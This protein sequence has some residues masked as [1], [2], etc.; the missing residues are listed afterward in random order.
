MTGQP[1]P[2]F[3][4]TELTALRELIQSAAGLI[5]DESRTDVLVAALARRMRTSGDATAG[6]YRKRLALDPDELHELLELVVVRE[7]HFARIPPQIDALRRVILPDLI[8]RR[9][10]ERRLRIWSAGCSTG[11]E[12]WTLAM[13]LAQLLPAGWDAQ[14][15]GTDLS[16]QALQVAEG[17][18]YGPRAVAQ[19]APEELQRWFSCDGDTYEIRAE[20]RPLVRFAAHNLVTDT[21]PLP[22][23]EHADLILCR[24]VT[25]YFDRPTTRR[26]VDGFRT[27]LAADGWLMMG[28]SETLWRLHDGFEV[29]SL[30]EAFAYRRQS[31]PARGR[32]ERRAER[33]PAARAPVHPPL[34]RRAPA[35]LR[36]GLLRTFAPAHLGAPARSTAA[37]E[38]PTVTAPETAPAPLGISLEGI[39]EHLL[40]GEYETAV[41]AAEAL[42]LRQPLSADA[43]YLHAVGLV[44]LGRDR[45]ALQPLRR[46]VYLAPGAPLPQF[47]LGT[48]LARL[49]SREAANGAF[50]AAEYALRKSDDLNA[51]VPELDGRPLRELAELCRQLR[52]ETPARRS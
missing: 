25:I 18:R 23:G 31:A 4:P 21:S 27:A 43:H 16:T 8:R 49:G 40:R 14:V 5:V 19:L 29:V 15:I 46:A 12:A 2:K 11:E 17:G 34:A 7:T 36:P 44:D 3:A 51:T 30:G 26:A 24:N 45:S 42:A 52:A 28:P 32:E 20:L 47:L 39:R 41:A 6:D 13:L 48:V 38:P 22:A 9:A 33:R 50:A 1:R 37:A 35:K 10:A